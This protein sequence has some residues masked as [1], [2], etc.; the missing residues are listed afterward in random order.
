MPIYDKTVL[1]GD[2]FLKIL[3]YNWREFSVNNVT[4]GCDRR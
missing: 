3:N 2:T 1:E 4:E